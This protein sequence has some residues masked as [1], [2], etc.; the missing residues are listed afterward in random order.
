MATYSTQSLHFASFLLCENWKLVNLELVDRRSGICEFIF[1]KEPG[2]DM[3]NLYKSW[4]LDE[5]RVPPR[6]FFTHYRTL[7]DL[8]D[9]TREGG[10]NETH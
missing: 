7:R 1:E 5:Y 3:S 4:S 2:T 6:A 10:G 9:R 8:L